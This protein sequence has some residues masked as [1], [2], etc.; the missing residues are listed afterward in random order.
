MSDYP[1]TRMIRQQGPLK[2]PYTCTSLHGT[3]PHNDKLRNISGPQVLAHRIIWEV[4][5]FWSVLYQ[6]YGL[7]EA[8]NKHHT[9]MVVFHI[10]NSL[11]TWNLGSET[12]CLLWHFS[13]FSSASPSKW[14]DAIW[15]V[16]PQLRSTLCINTVSSQLGGAVV[17]SY[18]VGL[19]LGLQWL[20][21]IT[22]LPELWQPAAGPSFEHTEVRN[23]SLLCI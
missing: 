11:R 4:P 3:T 17:V 23:S 18:N 22:D 15:T 19:Q 20:T 14:L 13:Y 7:H 6:I 8:E 10:L 5:S 2:R 12:G 21:Y 16:P 9:Q 1:P